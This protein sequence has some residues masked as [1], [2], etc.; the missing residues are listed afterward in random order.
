MAISPAAPDQSEYA[1]YYH[2][3]ISK[4]PE[5]DFLAV[6]A[7]QPES[8]QHLFSDLPDG[9]ESKLHEPYT[10]TLKQVLGHLIDVERIFST[11]LLCIGVGDE[12]ALPGMDQDIY[13][14]SFDYES[15]ATQTLLD[16]FAALRKANVI[17]AQRMSAEALERV[18]I[19]SESPVSA[20][21]NL[22]ILCGHVMYHEEIIRKRV[23]K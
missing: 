17:L 23:G 8:L 7:K 1:P 6:F 21:A 12:Q 19:A 9:E 10:W 18:G 5:G 22:Y 20:R 4:V 14:A 13:V 11:R 16:E 3:Y 2:Q 15:V